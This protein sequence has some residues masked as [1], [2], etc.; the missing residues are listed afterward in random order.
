MKE[1]EKLLQEARTL[2]DPTA[3]GDAEAHYQLK[4]QEWKK[5]LAEAEEADQILEDSKF[6]IPVQRTAFSDLV[7]KALASGS[8]TSIKDVIPQFG[9]QISAELTDEMLV[10]MVPQCREAAFE[11]LVEQLQGCKSANNSLECTVLEAKKE[12]DCLQ[13]E[14]LADDPDPK[15]A[16]LIQRCQDN[17]QKDDIKAQMMWSYF[18]PRELES[19]KAE[20]EETIRQGKEAAAT[21]QGA[22]TKQNSRAS[23]LSAELKQM[24]E[25][26]RLLSQVNNELQ[27]E[28]NITPGEQGELLKNHNAL[29]EECQGLYQTVKLIQ[30]KS[31]ELEAQL[32]AVSNEK[33][34]ISA[35]NNNL[36]QVHDEFAVTDA[37]R[38]SA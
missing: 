34:Q 33:D 13:A 10:K 7:D 3:I 24:E 9:E 32:A 14:L 17:R 26:V 21:A 5:E 31:Q 27:A 12:L 8:D 6:D 11:C 2:G 16:P 38:Y 29:Q 28:I 18:Q 36:L 25:K 30:I 15:I 19:I 20:Y 4:K 35:K 22:A 23:T 1:A 37:R